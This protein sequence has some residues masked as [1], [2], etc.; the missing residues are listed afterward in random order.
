MVRWSTMLAAA[1]ASAAWFWSYTPAA[2]T[3]LDPLRVDGP[4]LVL[5]IDGIDSNPHVKTFNIDATLPLGGYAFGYLEDAGFVPFSLSLSPAGS[6]VGT[7]AFAG[8]TLI[9]FALKQHSTGTIFNLSNPADYADQ[10]YFFPIDASLSENPV[11]PFTYYNKLVL[12]WDLDGNG[13][14]PFFDPRF[15]LTVAV[16]PHDGFAP[17]PLPATA[18]LFGGG[19]AGLG[20]ERLRRYAKSKG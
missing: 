15:T 7:H 13:F 6:W 16:N 5:A 3:G 10:L 9:D 17:V 14:H 11:V 1:L 2:A 19:L 20:I 4:G 18:V 12:E 8:G